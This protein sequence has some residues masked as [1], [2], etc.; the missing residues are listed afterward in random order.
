M[1]STRFKPEDIPLELSI[2]MFISS[3]EEGRMGVKREDTDR[4]RDQ[5]GIPDSDIIE[6]RKGQLQTV[7]HGRDATS[8]PLVRPRAPSS[9]T[10]SSILLHPPNRA[11]RDG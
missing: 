9:P 5:Y 7:A 11:R 3:R 10:T 8:Q 6:E 2:D 4:Y 1:G